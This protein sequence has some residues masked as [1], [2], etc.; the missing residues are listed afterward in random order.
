LVFYKQL[1]SFDEDC[2]TILKDQ[3]EK[4]KSAYIRDAV[5]F[6]T[7]NKDKRFHEIPKTRQKVVVEL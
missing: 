6:Y 3:P 4:K 5:K 1:V 2:L 7:N